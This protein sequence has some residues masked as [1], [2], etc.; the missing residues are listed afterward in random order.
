M[1]YYVVVCRCYRSSG[2]SQFKA[3][4]NFMGA[5]EMILA[6]QIGEAPGYAPGPKRR[7]LVGVFLEAVLCSIDFVGP[8]ITLT[9]CRS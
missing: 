9:P 4:S 7:G 3:E 2:Q 6:R 1:Y 5:A 8:V